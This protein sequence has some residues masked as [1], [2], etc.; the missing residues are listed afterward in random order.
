MYVDD[1]PPTY[2]TYLEVQKASLNDK[3]ARTLF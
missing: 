2:K 1:Q 3:K